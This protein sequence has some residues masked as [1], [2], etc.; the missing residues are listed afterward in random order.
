[1]LMHSAEG[2]WNTLSRML[3]MLVII[4]TFQKI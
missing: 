2:Y 1:M 3:Y 4:K